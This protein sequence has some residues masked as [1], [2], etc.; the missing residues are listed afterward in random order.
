MIFNIDSNCMDNQRIEIIRNATNRP[1]LHPDG[2]I[3]LKLNANSRLHVWPDI[4]II[5]TRNEAKIHDHVFKFRSEVLVGTLVETLYSARMSRD[6]DY[7]LYRVIPHALSSQ[8]NEPTLSKSSK[9]KL[10]LNSVRIHRSGSVYEL[11]SASIHK[12]EAV[13]L[14]AT[15]IS[16]DIDPTCKYASIFKHDNERAPELVDRKAI[17]SK[18]LWNHID[19]AIEQIGLKALH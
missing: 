10:A 7:E 5:D 15:V 17:S 8:P 12:T 19:Q 6:G 11:A 9:Y 2:F 1:I 13:G 14:T 18:L 3:Q 4:P 16:Y